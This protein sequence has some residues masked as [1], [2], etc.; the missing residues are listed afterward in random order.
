MKVAV[1]EGVALLPLLV[2]VLVASSVLVVLELVEFILLVKVCG[3]IAR[4]E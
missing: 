2:L 4:R 1:T 3:K